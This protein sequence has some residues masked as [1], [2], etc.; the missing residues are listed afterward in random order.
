MRKTKA[1]P[2]P[3]ACVVCGAKYYGMSGWIFYA[4][5]GMKTGAPWCEK[6][7]KEMARYANPVFEN[8]EALTLFKSI[9]PRLYVRDV[10]DK[11]ILFLKG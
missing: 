5:G 9:H 8:Q 6:H 11:E 10:K 4:D 1:R 2:V 7:A 3:E